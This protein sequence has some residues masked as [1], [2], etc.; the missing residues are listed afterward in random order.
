MIGRLYELKFS[1]IRSHHAEAKHHL[2]LDFASS[3][4]H[5]ERYDAGEPTSQTLNA[6]PA[7]H[8]KTGTIG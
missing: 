7:P 2:T 5:T 4:Y 8:P 3:N 6:P 1:Y